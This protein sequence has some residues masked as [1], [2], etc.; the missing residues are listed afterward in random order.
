MESN[1]I[2]QKNASLARIIIF[3][4]GALGFILSWAIISGDG[5]G[6]VNLLHVVFLYVLLPI[7]S[8][9][10][11]F[12]SFSVHSKWNFPIIVG[13]LPIVGET[14]RRLFLSLSQNPLSRLWFFY[15]GQLAALFFSFA[16]LIVLLILLLVSD[17][18]FV[19]RSTLLDANDLHQILSFIAMPWSF[20]DAGQPGIALLELTKESRLQSLNDRPNAFGDWWRFVFAS[21]LFYAIGLRLTAW[22]VSRIV[23]KRSGRTNSSFEGKPT[24]QKNLSSG[25]HA[26]SSVPIANNVTQDFALTNWAGLSES[27]IETIEQQLTANKLSILSAG[28]LASS[29]DEITAQR[30]QGTQ[31]ILVKGWEPPLAELADYMQNGIGFLLPLDW[32]NGS[33]DT[34]A[35]DNNLDVVKDDNS[36]A[37]HF[38]ELPANYLAEWQRFIKGKPQWQLLVLEGLY[39]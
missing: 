26:T 7:I 27:D 15:V 2:I 38:K 36:N 1:D 10:V 28:P 9:I 19:W 3:F 39:D 34:E 35:N 37:L 12:F 21:Q 20:W 4:A 23:L 8:L 14:N 13:S 18:N 16:S 25:H 11:S 29:L 24:H 30:W 33:E 6:R 31:V 17:V 32:T 22:F 5:Q